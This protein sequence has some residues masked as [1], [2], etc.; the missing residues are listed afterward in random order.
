LAAARRSQISV[1]KKCAIKISLLESYQ[2]YLIGMFYNNLLP[3][4]IGGDVFR[5]CLI[6]QKAQQI[7][8]VSSTVFIERLTGFFATLS[9]SLL[10]ALVLYRT[11]HQEIYVLYLSGLFMGVCLVMLLFFSPSCWLFIRRTTELLHL[12]KPFQPIEEFAAI[13]QEYK[14]DLGLLFKMLVLSLF[15]QLSD[16]FVAYLFSRTIGF[17]VDFIFFLLFIPLVYITTLIP[18]SFNGL[19]VRENVMV[20]L[21]STLGTATH[22]VLLLS[23]LI[24]MDRIVKGALGGIL[25]LVVIAIE[26]RKGRS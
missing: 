13:V 21:F 6:N 17:D 9:L 22:K 20:Y 11:Q 1:Q 10:A 24:Y 14:H 2:Y 18:I 3:T 15:Y 4:S 5:I 16:I 7:Y 23:L 8:R 25:N 19:G 26:T 12:Q